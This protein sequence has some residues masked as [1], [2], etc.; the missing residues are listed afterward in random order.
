M[1]NTPQAGWYPDPQNGSYLRW[2]DGFSWTNRTTEF[3]QQNN[4]A[5]IEPSSPK[6]VPL[7]GARKVAQDLQE[8]NK[9]L[10][11][12]INR[13]GLGEFSELDGELQKIRQELLAEQEQLHLAK[14]EIAQASQDVIDLREWAELQSNGLFDYEHPAESSDELASEL[15]SLRSKIKQMI[16]SGLATSATNNFSFNNS[17]SKGKK[18]VND[19]SKL[20]LRSYNSEAENC[21][22]SVKHG[23]LGSCQRRLTKAAEQVQR[24]GGMINL[25]ITH[26]YHTLRLY[27]LEL[28][29]RHLIAKKHEQELERERRAELREQKR[30]EA[31]LKK[32][33]E[34]LSKEKNHYENVLRQLT[35]NGDVEGAERTRQKIEEVSNSLESVDFR[36]ANIKAGYVYIISN[37]G[38][39]GEGVVKIGMTRRLEPMDRVREL[40]DASVP[41]KFDV[42]ALF[43]SDNAVE[44]ET[45][46]HKEF[47][48]HRLNKIN[49]RREFFR[50]TPNEVLE[51]LRK[52]SVE[53]LEFKVEA[54]AEE[55]RAS[56]VID[57][58]HHP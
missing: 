20:M 57:S 22:K 5:I 48:D 56:Q 41:F 24:L 11:N 19:M 40:G 25:S 12:L 36:S 14:S 30:V 53:I 58:S 26:N 45:M 4:P 31:E 9:R 34:R 32:E 29:S 23:N 17:A 46:L 51:K 50:V 47:S 21:L 44:I 10:T 15:D 13:Y 28:A 3:T 7:F 27:E 2:W 37:Q 38:A 18:F 55:F 54:D 16:K 52:H 42:H 43:F 49:L 39:F 35:E 33:R 1:S 6:K 8:Q